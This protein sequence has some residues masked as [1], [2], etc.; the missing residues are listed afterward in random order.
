MSSNLD[1]EK[2]EHY[3]KIIRHGLQFPY[4]GNDESEMPQPLTP[5][6]KAAYG[7][8]EELLGRKG[9]D[10]ALEDIDQEIR[11]EL[12]EAVAGIVKVAMSNT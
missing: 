3:E 7:V 2:I 6:R 1:K 5:E 11:K 4:D 12:V 8:I 9:L 10:H